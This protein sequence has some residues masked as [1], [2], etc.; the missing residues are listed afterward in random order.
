MECYFGLIMDEDILTSSGNSNPLNPKEQAVPHT[1]G[2]P[3][4][5]KNRPDSCK[6]YCS[7]RVEAT[8]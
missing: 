3:P 5:V 6:K 7:I 2:R 8:I 1:K 4:G